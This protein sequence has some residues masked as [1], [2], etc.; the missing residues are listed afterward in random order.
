MLEEGG[1]DW[2]LNSNQWLTVVNT[3][4]NL[5]VPQYFLTQTA[6]VSFSKKGSVAWSYILVVGWLYL[7]IHVTARRPNVALRIGFLRI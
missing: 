7:A 3:E 1:L 4:M 2:S 5:Q 6:T